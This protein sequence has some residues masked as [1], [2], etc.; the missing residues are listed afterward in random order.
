MIH[1]TEIPVRYAETDAMGVVYHANYL[2]WFEVARTEFLEAL[3]QPY[4]SFEEK[5]I[6]SP[7]LHA[8]CDYG[9]SLRYGDTAIVY[10]KVTSVTGVKTVFEYEVYKQGQSPETDKPCC[11]GKTLHCLVRK[12][13]FKPISMKKEAPEL[14][15]TYLSVLEEPSA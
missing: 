11:S 8:E 6:M 12:E 4:A 3:G 15:A 5:G 1:R 7:V 2:I 14:L 10:T 13:D 9:M